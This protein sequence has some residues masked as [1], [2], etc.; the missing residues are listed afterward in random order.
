M[1]KSKT[2]TS[3]TSSRFG[4]M[5]WF[6]IIYIAVLLFLAGFMVGDGFNILL[7]TFGESGL[8]LPE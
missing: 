5:G 2:T 8:I 7:P 1:A 3:L 6:M 4:T